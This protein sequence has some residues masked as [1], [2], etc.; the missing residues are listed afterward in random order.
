MSDSPWAALGSATEFMAAIRAGE[1]RA[2]AR[3]ITLIETSLDRLRML[4]NSAQRLEFNTADLIDAP[5]VR[6]LHIFLYPGTRTRP[7]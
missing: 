6:P 5:R 4:V 7:C 2:L 1:R 3:A